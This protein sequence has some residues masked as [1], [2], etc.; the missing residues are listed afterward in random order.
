MQSDGGCRQGVYSPLV[1]YDG[2]DPW[3]IRG[4]PMQALSRSC[5]DSSA[6]LSSASFPLPP[7]FAI[8]ILKHTGSIPQIEG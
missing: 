8:A 4:K 2:I 7:R 6:V 3:Y 1:K 5:R